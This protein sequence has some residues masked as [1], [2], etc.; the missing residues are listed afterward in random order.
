MPAAIAPA[1]AAD[2]DDLLPLFAGYQRF[3]AGHAQP[4]RHNRAFLT[5]FIPPHH[6]GMLLV[7]R[8]GTGR[9]V[10]FANLY[11]TFSSVSAR[12]H[13]LMNDLFVGDDVRGGGVGHALIEAAATVARDRG[14]PALSWQTAVDNRV[15]QRLYERFDAERTIWFEYEIAVGD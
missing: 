15:A 1:T 3:Y 13:V 2:L 4:D 10:G 12:E 6:D 9:A 8:D 14:A 11:W 7:A 5:R